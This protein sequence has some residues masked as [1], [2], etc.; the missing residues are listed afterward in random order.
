[1]G[2]HSVNTKANQEERLRFIQQLLN[3][4]DALEELLKSGKIESGIQRIGAEQEFCLIDNTYKPSK[5]AVSILEAI[6]DEHFTTELATYNLEINLDP[7]ELKDKAF[8]IVENQLNSL[9][10]KARTF[11]EKEENKILLCGILP[12]IS[13]QE[14]RLDYMTPNPRY[15]AL[16]ERM[17]G[18]R[19]NDFSLH[20]KGVDELTVKHD[21]VLFEAC[22]TSFQMHLQIEPSDFISAYNWSQAISGPVLGVSANSPLLLGR[23]LWNETRIA[24]F[25][26]S[27]DTRNSSYALVDQQARVS[28]GSDWEKGSIV[29]VYKNEIANYKIILTKEIE[30]NSLE[31]IARG[32]TPKLPALNLHNGTIYR[33]N[34]PCYG[35][36]GGKAHLRIE[37]RY[38]PSGPSVEDEM[39]NFAFWVGLMIGRPKKFDDMPSTMDFRDAKANF[40]KASRT[41]KHSVLVW[42]N[43]S[44]KLSELI[45]NVLL[46]VAFEGLRKAQI[47]EKDIQR[48]LGI[49]AARCKG[50]TGAQWQIKNFRSLRKQ[51]KRDQ[52]LRQLTAKMLENQSKRLS[53]HN[54][55][56]LDSDLAKFPRHASRVGDIMSTQ[57]FTV[58]ENDLAELA[59]RV[60][61]WKNIHH[62][63]VENN[64]KELCGIL[65]WNH[66][67]EF[68]KNPNKKDTLTVAD[69][70]I[71][72]VYQVE[73]DHS[74]EEASQLMKEK[75]IG[76][77]PIVEK[78]TLVG[79]LTV[80]DLLEHEAD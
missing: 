3:D 34:R 48:L 26:Q 35:V 77:L 51:M 62:L 30:T 38:I 54:W 49:I 22:N 80:K 37:N 75:E 60:M 12:T 7:V 65:T 68:K 79:I 13:K 69:I 64:H 53:V 21:S 56:M 16:N 58:N 76:C 32:E 11:A 66:I 19:G 9:L 74:I 1:M 50:N 63:P 33:W 43:Q 15:W 18:L 8:S 17:K 29:D 78:N 72:E 28:F 67:Q 4:I 55:P 31:Q 14:L 45:E 23:E 44:Y 57:L 20:L 71:K 25:Q 40:Y 52:A 70:M 46:P 73:F 61:M 27:I 2:D 42:E 6:Q 59:I 47:D 5:K 10:E 24:L 36:G 41:G 39:A